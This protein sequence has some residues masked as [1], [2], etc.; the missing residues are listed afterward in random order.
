MNKTFNINLGGLPF[1]IDDDAYD[2]LTA[3]LRAI[4]K[5]FSGSG[6]YK[7]ITSDIESRL[8]E[9]L[10]ER[11]AA[12]S[13]VVK[14]DIS[15]VINTMGRP[16]DFGAEPME[17]NIGGS[18]TVGTKNEY[19]T[20]KKLFRDPENTVLGGV[21]SGVA[22]YFGVQDPLWVR[23]TFLL[24][25]WTGFSPVI[26]FILWII[27]P[28]AQTAG[29]RLAMRGEPINVSNIAKTVEE[30]VNNISEAFRNP[31]GKD[32]TRTYGAQSGSGA[33]K[34]ATD[35][36]FFFKEILGRIL[37]IFGRIGR[38]IVS[39]FGVFFAG[40]FAILWLSFLVIIYCGYPFSDYL[41]GNDTWTQLWFVASISILFLIPLFWAIY[42]VIKL[43]FS[44]N[45]I[46]KNVR[47][48]LTV[49]WILNCFGL[50]LLGAY[51]GGQF[52][53][54]YEYTKDNTLDDIESDTIVLS[55]L[56]S[57]YRGN[58][59][60]FNSFITEDGLATPCNN[61]SIEKSEDKN[62]LLQQ[63]F[64]ANGMDFTEAENLTKAI[65]YPMQL[66]SNKLVLPGD[67][68]IPRGTKWRAQTVDM[69][70]FIP[71]GKYIK[72]DENTRHHF[73][74]FNRRT[75][76]RGRHSN[77]NFKQDS[78]V[79]QMQS[80]G[81]LTNSD[82]VKANNYSTTFD[83]KNFNKIEINGKMKVVV[84]QGKTYSIVLKGN[85]EDATKIKVRQSNETI[86]VQ[87]EN[88]VEDEDMV[89]EITL[90]DL[91]V[92]DI[93]DTNEVTLEGIK[94]NKLEL[95]SRGDM[96]IEGDIEVTDLRVKIENGI[97]LT[98]KGTAETLDL[99]TRDNADFRG[100]RFRV[101]TSKIDADGNGKIEVYAK[102]QVKI[103]GNNDDVTVE[104]DA[105]VIK[106]K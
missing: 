17:E 73:G 53:R 68:I 2:F 12:R 7:E 4:H 95:F 15:H 20:G 47:I 55:F 88:E 82:D 23:L 105:E 104:G 60:T 98:L 102:K 92:L 40:V 1:V 36:M 57:K 76:F 33:G 14:D 94:T 54:E 56:D 79:Y 11:L 28:K 103:T 21:C 80:D 87:G 71:V 63:R 9:L 29:E 25:V 19:R 27:L 31:N 81:E 67:L 30:E 83:Y 32:N 86:H 39:L 84:K 43:F 42:A 59:N 64:S 10:Q 91:E 52:N 70:L 78:R 99:R 77:R 16:E 24:L 106:E 13:I 45:P 46:P 41:F 49:L 35:V 93:E 8:A 34:A 18:S 85:K 101:N 65:N 100:S 3:Y 66:Q 51:F 69:K 50:A 5:H 74:N 48:G 72:F 61:L 75:S 38:P 44:V 89:I 97:V 6:S 96:K 58:F 22:A 90:P 62:F 26:Y 37:H